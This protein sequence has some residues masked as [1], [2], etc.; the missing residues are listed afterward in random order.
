MGLA[1]SVRVTQI[2]TVAT[3]GNVNYT[4]LSAAYTQTGFT[5][6]GDLAVGDFLTFGLT[7]L[8]LD[9]STIYGIEVDVTSNGTGTSFSGGM[10]ARGSNSYANGNFYTAGI[11][12]AGSGGTYAANTE[13]LTFYTDISVAPIPE[14]SATLLGWLG[15]LALLL[16]RR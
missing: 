14:P 6:T 15:M 11:N 3:T 8:A 13:Y 4:A 2:D 10:S 7:P 16:R 9:S 1:F 12:F 5:F